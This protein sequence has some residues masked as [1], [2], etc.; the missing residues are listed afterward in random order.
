MRYSHL[1]LAIELDCKHIIE[2]RI[3]I[4]VILLERR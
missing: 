1:W 4:G 3:L 2:L